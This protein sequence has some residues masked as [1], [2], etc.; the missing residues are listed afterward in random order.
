MSAEIV[1]K[2]LL[3]GSAAV[4][5]LVGA[6][7]VWVEEAPLGAPLPLLIL[8]QVSRVERRTVAR[9]EAVLLVTSRIQVTA[10]AE[11]YAAKKQLLAAV[12]Q[13]CGNALGTV[14]GIAG[15]CTRAD[16]TGP[17]MR[18]DQRGVSA[19]SQDFIVICHEPGYL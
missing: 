3:Q 14:A 16:V 12:R 19:Q 11:T 2:A 8:E 17:D 13:A 6:D 4:T 15:V 18:D 7:G 10:L 9:N 1:M 5:A